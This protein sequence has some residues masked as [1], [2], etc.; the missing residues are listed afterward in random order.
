V[1]EWVITLLCNQ[2]VMGSNQGPNTGYPSKDFCTPVKIPWQFKLEYD[3]LF[4]VIRIKLFIHR[5]I[6][7][8]SDPRSTNQDQAKKCIY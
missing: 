5:H 6:I 8:R 2:D 4:H 3:C 7:R 1:V